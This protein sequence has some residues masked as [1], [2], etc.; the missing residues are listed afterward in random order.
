MAA[1]QSA[2]APGQLGERRLK[3]IHAVAQALAIGPMFSVALVLG[4]VSNPLTGAGFNAAL[5]VLIAGLGVL[6]IGYAYSLF[7]RRYAGAGAVYEYLTHGA[8]PNL[9]ILTAGFFFLGTLFLGGGG[10]YLGLGILA[11]GFWTAHISSSNAPSWWVFAMLF[12]VLALVV[13]YLGIRI[14]I[15]IMLT[16]AA[17]SVVPMLYLAIAIIAKGGAGGNT[18]AVFNPSTTSVSTAFN[19]VLLGILLFVGFEAAA[20]IGEESSEPH[21]S[22][23]RAVLGTVGASAVFFV[24]MAYA[25]SIGYG[26]AAVAKG[27]W[28]ADPAALDT[29]ATQY[30][31]HW[32]ATIIDLVVI[33]DAT[34]L[35]LAIC[36]TIG[37]GYFALAR[38]GLLPSVFAKTSRHNTPWVGNLM[39]AV[40]GI[41]LTLL[42]TSTGIADKYV[43]IFGSKQFAVFIISATAGSFAIE[44]V[45]LVLAVVALR[46]VYQMN[47]TPGQWWRYPVIVVAILTPLLGFKGALWPGPHTTANPNWEAMYW[48]LATLVLAVVWFLVVRITRPDR[49]RNAAMHA[50]HHQGVTPL[51]EPFQPNPA[52]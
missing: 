37:R 32:L 14:A 12:L 36:V 51:D 39:V 17:V 29:M 27:A 23:P 49:V 48:A 50:S 11:N 16:F 34:A 43:P 38:D 13:N 4:G 6:A 7:A 28:A 45:Y 47:G 44:L 8:H 52:G 35:S 46:L 15:G 42:V 3:T 26:K 20:S 5:S 9:G 22:I 2:A 18:F 33:L 24:I 19:G 1:T 30:V 31:G 25:I 10:I 21:R 41:G 40:G